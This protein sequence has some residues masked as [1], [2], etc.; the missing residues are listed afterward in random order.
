MT[1]RFTRNDKCRYG[2]VWDKHLKVRRQC[3]AY[4]MKGEVRCWNHYRRR[5]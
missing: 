1:V 5:E 4:P 3:R 2:L